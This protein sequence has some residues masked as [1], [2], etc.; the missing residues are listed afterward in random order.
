LER[1]SIEAALPN[2]LFRV[3]LDDG[4]IL[5]AGLSLEARRVL[6]KVLPGDRV[7]VEVG[8]FDPSRGKIIG[9]L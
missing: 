1:G 3:R 9:R 4:R 5:V 7:I 8:E 2:T 6:V